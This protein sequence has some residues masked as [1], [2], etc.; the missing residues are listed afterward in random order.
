[1]EGVHRGDVLW[2]RRLHP[3]ANELGHLERPGEAGA[4]EVAD[5]GEPPRGGPRGVAASTPLDLK[6]GVG[7]VGEEGGIKADV[8]EDGADEADGSKR[9]QQRA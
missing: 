1:M 9:C 8:A 4:V 7:A 3:D 5:G 2:E 6:G